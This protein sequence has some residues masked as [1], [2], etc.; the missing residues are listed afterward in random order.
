[1]GGL[2]FENDEK[3]LRCNGFSASERI[4]AGVWGGGFRPDFR[5]NI[6]ELESRGIYPRK[7]LVG[8]GLKKGWGCAGLVPREGIETNGRFSDASTELI[9][10]AGLVSRKGIETPHL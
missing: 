3:T 1:M 2:F 8:Q 6:E 5:N 4:L 7:T 9:C 10:C